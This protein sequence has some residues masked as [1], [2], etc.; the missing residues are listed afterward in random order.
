MPTKNFDAWWS[1]F[2]SWLG[3]CDD[4]HEAARRVRRHMLG[5]RS[6][7]QRKFFGQ[8]LERLLQQRHA[9]GVA[10]F[11]LEG[12]TDPD[13]LNDVAEHLLPLPPVQSD[14]EES[15]LAD[16]IRILA[17]ANDPALL[18][19]IGAYV[20]ERPIGPHWASVPWALWPHRKKLFARSWRRFFLEHQP[21]DWKNTLVIK[22]FLTEPEAIAVVRELLTEECAEVW[23]GLRA[24]L[25]RQ[26]GL[27]SWLS[28]EQRAELDRA[29]V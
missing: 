1:D 26:A 28:E 24:A 21:A 12:V 20:L 4:V 9:Y 3:Q 16:L 18:P 23:V 2:E 13:Y 15:H 17:A 25:I 5:L 22:S 19:A 8:V 14:D 29:I 6:V 10:L 27:A 7:R 11:M